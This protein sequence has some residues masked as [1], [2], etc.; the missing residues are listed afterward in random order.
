MHAKQIHV[1][2]ALFAWVVL[3]VPGAASA[4]EYKVVVNASNPV[5]TV[6]SAQ[7]S[8]IF[9]K[10]TTRWPDGSSAMPIDQ[11]WSSEV[12]EEFSTAVHERSAEAIAAYWQ[13]V[14][15]SGRAVPPV[16]KASDAE[17]LMAVRDDPNAVGYVSPSTP[18]GDGVKVVT[19]TG[20]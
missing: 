4:Q 6:G 16:E 2:I 17:V 12:R 11:L 18:V 9:L 10:K 7:L 15:F 20:I 8:R 1:V 13:R 5:T 14:I 3:L 19:V